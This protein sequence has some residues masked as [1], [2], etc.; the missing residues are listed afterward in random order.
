MTASAPPSPGRRIGRYLQG[1]ELAAGGMATVYVG[2]AQAE[3]VDGFGR[4]VALKQ[5]HPPYARDPEVV[6]MFLNEARLAG[7]L[8]HPNV[9]PIVDVVTEDNEVVLVMDY[10]DGLSLS[11]VRKAARKAA[12]AIPIDVCLRITLDLLAGLQAA[13]EARGPDGMP[14]GL[15]HR[16]VSPQNVIVDRSGVARLLDFGIA[17]VARGLSLTR[18]GQLK[19]KLSYMAPEQLKQRPLDARTDVYAAAIVCWELLAGEPLFAAENDAATFGR[20]LEGATC[21]PSARRAEVSAKLDAVIMRA[22]ALAPQDRFASAGAFA[23]ALAAAAPV[24]DHPRVAAFVLSHVHEALET[25]AQRVRAWQASLASA[26]APERAPVVQKAIALADRD[27]AEAP[28]AMLTAA[29]VRQAPRATAR[30]R[31]PLLSAAVISG[32]ALL[33]ANW[34]W[35]RTDE[36]ATSAAPSDQPPA[37]ITRPGV[38]RLPLTPEAPPTPALVQEEPVRKSVAPGAPRRAVT[39]PTSHRRASPRDN[40]AAPASATRP[41]CRQ[42]F[43]VDQ[44]GVRVPRPECLP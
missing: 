42:P 2:H 32:V 31:W 38:E 22:L 23:T 13:H 29:A 30:R 19:G 9:V 16:D 39:K 26:P 15:V 33:G 6:A 17:K 43:V 24:A 14:L 37:V 35:A 12:Q 3:G 36:F 4:L 34:W 8:H 28:T 10:V 7:R 20:A 21:P 44:A 40:T 1:E 27:A 41:D 11:S 18:E 5:L 25:R